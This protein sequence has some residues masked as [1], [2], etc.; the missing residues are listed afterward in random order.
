MI[1]YSILIFKKINNLP[2]M[3]MMLSKR[4]KKNNQ[5]LKFW[6]SSTVNCQVIDKQNCRAELPDAQYKKESLD[7]YQSHFGIFYIS[8]RLKMLRIDKEIQYSFSFHCFLHFFFSF[9]LYNINRSRSWSYL[10]R[11]RPVKH[12]DEAAAGDDDN[13]FWYWRYTKCQYGKILFYVGGFSA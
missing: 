8:R 7:A 3:M 12:D 9:F 2:M 13:D 1:E 4:Y 10:L 11:I 5:F 6:K